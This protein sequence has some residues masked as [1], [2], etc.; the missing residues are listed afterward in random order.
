MK[1]Q[2]KQLV[3][4]WQ[5]DVLRVTSEYAWARMGPVTF[6]FGALCWMCPC[7]TWRV[8]SLE[9]PQLCQ[10]FQNPDMSAQY[11]N[12]VSLLS[13]WHLRSWLSLSGLGLFFFSSKCHLAYG[14]GVFCIHDSSCVIM[15]DNVCFNT[16]FDFFVTHGNTMDFF[17]NFS[18]LSLATEMSFCPQDTGFSP[19]PRLLKYCGFVTKSKNS[20]WAKNAIP[21]SNFRDHFSS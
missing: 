1:A 13:S 16:W 5:R 6:C 9:K 4:K 18:C 8:P 3:E 7:W 12:R 10:L 2:W 19:P 20:I 21:F 14:F 15:T 11:T 17:F